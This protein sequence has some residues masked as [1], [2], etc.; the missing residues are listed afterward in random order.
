MLI[1]AGRVVEVDER[2]IVGRGE[3]DQLRGVERGAA[4]HRDEQ[5]GL[6]GLERGDAVEDVLLDGVRVDLVEDRG[7][8]P[9]LVERGRDAL[10]EA[11]L[12]DAR[13]AHDE[14]A[15]SVRARVI[16]AFKVSGV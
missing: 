16:G 1:A 7:R 4:A 9:R 14:R 12:R 2:A 6:R 15:L 8:D 11:E 13:V 3:A 5:I 10:G